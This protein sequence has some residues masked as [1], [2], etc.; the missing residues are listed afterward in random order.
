[1]CI[2]LKKHIKIQQKINYDKDHNKDDDDQDDD[3]EDDDDDDFFSFFKKFFLNKYFKFES[4]KQIH[5]K[6]RFLWRA[7]CGVCKEGCWCCFRV[8]IG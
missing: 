3:D 2:N 4:K 1:M 5:F 6:G 8:C 7:L